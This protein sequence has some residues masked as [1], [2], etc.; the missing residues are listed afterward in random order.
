[1]FIYYEVVQ[2]LDCAVLGF[3]N[4]LD[5]SLHH[6]F[7]FPSSLALDHAWAT[8]SSFGPN[9]VSYQRLRAL[10]RKRVVKKYAN[11]RAFLQD[12]GTSNS[13]ESILIIILQHRALR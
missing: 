5:W 13:F 12:I 3:V 11:A 9:F 4:I 10:N 1:M 7:V 2:H 8:F 6:T